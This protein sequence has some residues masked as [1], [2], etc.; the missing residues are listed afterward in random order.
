[1]SKLRAD[2]TWNRRVNSN[3]SI[4]NP[5]NIITDIEKDQMNDDKNFKKNIENIEDFI[6]NEELDIDDE[7]DSIGLENEFNNYLHGWTEMLEEE[8]F[9]FQNEDNEIDDFEIDD[10][11]D[12]IIHPAIDPNAKWNL[13]SLF[14]DLE[15][16]F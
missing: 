16:H 15:L 13:E 12:D 2:I 5:I 4:S 6:L 10:L 1:M 9:R 3:S 14:K 7:S 11:I 8:N